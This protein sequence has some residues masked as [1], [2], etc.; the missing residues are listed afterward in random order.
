[1]SGIPSD[2][3]EYVAADQRRLQALAYTLTGTREDAE[4]LVQETLVRVLCAWRRIDSRGPLGYSVT[5]MCRLAMKRRHRDVR[6]AEHDR[7]TVDP[8]GGLDTSLMVHGALR[9]LPPRQRAVIGLRY[10]CDL[11]E[12]QTA[13][14][15]GC[16]LGTVKS[17]SS[18][19]MKSLRLSLT[20]PVAQAQPP[21]LLEGSES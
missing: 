11:T 2:F 20:G 16:S 10:L 21:A 18:K 14:A 5:V 9:Q 13:A 12:A 19:A 7:P 8:A 6:L 1:M 3:A 4:D 15:L 17:Q